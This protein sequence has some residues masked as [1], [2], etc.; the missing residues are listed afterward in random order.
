MNKAVQKAI[1][2]AIKGRGKLLIVGRRGK[3]VFS[4]LSKKNAAL[5]PPAALIEAGYEAQQALR[6]PHHTVSAAAIQNEA[7]IA[8]ILVLD[9]VGSFP[10]YIL[11]ALA[12]KLKT[13]RSKP[14]VIMLD[15][16]DRYGILGTVSVVT[17]EL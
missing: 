12:G 15:N 6:M 16:L 13:M 10:D 9:D 4:Y 2:K 1:D 8:R 7:E 14:T 11:Q 17:H 5:K 3:G